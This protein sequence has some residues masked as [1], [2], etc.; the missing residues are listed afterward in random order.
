MGNRY[1]EDGNFSQ[2]D[3]DKALAKYL[4][5]NPNCDLYEKMGV[6]GTVTKNIT[7]RKTVSWLKDV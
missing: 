1:A 5:E 2:A 4:N 6:S 3:N 7:W